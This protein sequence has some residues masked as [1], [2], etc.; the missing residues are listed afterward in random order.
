ML[1]TLLESYFKRSIDS[2]DAFDQT[3]LMYA[4]E[5][6]RI[7]LVEI[8]LENGS[9]T[10]IK[11]SDNETAL[12]IASRLDNVSIIAVLLKAGADI[13]AANLDGQTP[14]MVAVLNFSYKAARFLLENGAETN[15]CDSGILGYN[16]LVTCKIQI[17]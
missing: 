1:R 16:I 9:D 15:K 17:V 3:A 5:R 13:E 7:D 2:R 12:I 8:L 4:T 11:N 10:E 14:L 6:G